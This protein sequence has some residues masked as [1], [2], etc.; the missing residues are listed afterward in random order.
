VISHTLASLAT[1]DASEI[2]PGW[3]GGFEPIPTMRQVLTEGKAAGWRVMVEI[4]D[5]PL[6][7][8]FD[9][10]GQNVANLLIPLINSIGFPHDRIMIQ[11][12]WP[13]ALDAVQLKAPDIQTVFLTSST[14]PSAPHGVGI[15]ALANVLYSAARGYTVSSPAIDTSDLT[16][17]VVSLAHILGRQVVPYTPDTPADITKAI[18]LGADGVISNRPDLVFAL[19]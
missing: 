15:P 1:C 14:L 16:A 8:N 12:F 4:K 17:T 18:I 6:E 19:R 2:F 10:T 3:A 7:A 13:L 11:S 9:A 5:I